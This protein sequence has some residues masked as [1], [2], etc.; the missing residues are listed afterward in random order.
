V[1]GKVFFFF[2]FSVF[3]GIQFP[4][5]DANPVCIFWEIFALWIQFLSL[6]I[7]LGKLTIGKKFDKAVFGL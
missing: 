3:V 7:F 4:G 1:S 6:Y 2:F 5:K